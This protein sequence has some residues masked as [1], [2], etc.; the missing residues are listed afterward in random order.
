MIN[1]YRNESAFPLI[2]IAYTKM[3][4][5]CCHRVLTLNVDTGIEIMQALDIFLFFFLACSLLWIGFVLLLLLIAGNIGGRNPKFVF[6]DF[7]TKCLLVIAPLWAVCLPYL[8]AAYA[9]TWLKISALIAVGIALF[10]TIPWA[11]WYLGVVWEGIREKFIP[12]KIQPR[13]NRRRTRL[14]NPDSLD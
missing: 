9:P 10:P 3:Q 2:V 6:V 11:E 4:L 12:K 8:I 13:T 1:L 14:T 7:L 5:N